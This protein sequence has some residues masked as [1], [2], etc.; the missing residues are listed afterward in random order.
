MDSFDFKAEEVGVEQE[1]RRGRI[2]DHQ[3]DRL[4]EVVSLGRAG[5][6][7]ELEG[8]PVAEPHK[9]ADPHGNH[10]AQADFVQPL[11]SQFGNDVGCQRAVESEDKHVSPEEGL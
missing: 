2:V 11:K 10:G 7:H 3:E 9:E 1:Y 8:H 6:S 5:E 4:K